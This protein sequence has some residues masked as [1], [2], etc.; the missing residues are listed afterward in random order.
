V[1]PTSQGATEAYRVVSVAA[2]KQRPS[3]T[4]GRNLLLGASLGIAIAFVTF[5][6]KIAIADDP[7]MA[8]SALLPLFV[9]YAAIGAI[10]WSPVVVLAAGHPERVRWAVV[11]AITAIALTWLAAPILGLVT[12]VFFTG[13]VAAIVGAVWARYVWRNKFQHSV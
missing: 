1:A 10:G 2:A 6:V 5:V 8:I 4:L 11:F 3:R 12:G 13:P 9:V 7:G